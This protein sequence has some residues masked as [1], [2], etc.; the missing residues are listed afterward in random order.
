MVTQITRFFTRLLCWG[1][2]VLGRKE[3]HNGQNCRSFAFRYVPFVLS[4]GVGGSRP[5]CSDR[6]RVI[7][8]LR[9]SGWADIPID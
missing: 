6:A 5:E 2:L 9:A 8:A 4:C 1:P 7:L 3:G